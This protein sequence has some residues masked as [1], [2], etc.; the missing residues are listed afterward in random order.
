MSNVSMIDGHIDKEPKFTDEEIIKSFNHCLNST[1]NNCDPCVFKSVVCDRT[2][3]GK[4]ETLKL[5]ADVFNRLQAENERLKA[6]QQTADRYADALV[7]YTKEKAIKELIDRLEIDYTFE[8]Q[9]DD[10]YWEK[11]VRL[12]SIK[13]IVKEM[14]GEE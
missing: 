7:E 10:G 4:I 1:D 8:I 9:R 2:L 12:E 11:V 3:R 6:E 13:A 14:V 5:V